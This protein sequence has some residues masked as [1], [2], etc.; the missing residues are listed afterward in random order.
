MVTGQ[1]L[2]IALQ[3]AEERE[4]A[5]KSQ[6]EVANYLKITAQA[7]SNWENGRSKIDSVSL[8]KCLLWFKVDIYE[9]LGR[10]D[11]EIMRAISDGSAEAE[12]KLNDLLT[13]LNSIGKN[14][15]IDYAEDLVKSGAYAKEQNTSEILANENSVRPA[16]MTRE[17]YHAELDRQLDDEEK[18]E[19]NSSVSGRPASGSAGA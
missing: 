13:V 19:E 11:F 10:C 15:V 16:P 2:K 18:A 6:L 14:K 12:N 1:Y 17:Q 3:F 7:V 4:K 9:F 5:Q 8:L